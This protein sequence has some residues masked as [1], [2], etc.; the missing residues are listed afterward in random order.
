MVKGQVTLNLEDYHALI[1]SKI[2]SL[3]SQEKTDRLLKELQ[4]FLSFMV[5]RTDISPYV[6]EFNKQ[7]KTSV[8]EINTNGTVKIIKK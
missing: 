6:T 3:E 5:T 7:S 8:I 1:N 4:V 2:I